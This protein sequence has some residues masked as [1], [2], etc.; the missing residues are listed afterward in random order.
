[1]NVRELLASIGGASRIAED[2][3]LTVGRVSQWQ[4]ANYIPRAW[5]AL[6]KARFP[7]VQWQSLKM[8]KSEAA[9][10]AA[11][12]PKQQKRKEARIIRLQQKL[13]SLRQS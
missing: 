5:L 10:R 6:L 9:G 4:T 13:E 12:K 2:C 3:E 1:M 7:L 11:A 8:A